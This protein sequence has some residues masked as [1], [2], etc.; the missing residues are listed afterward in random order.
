MTRLWRDALSTVSPGARPVAMPP[1]FYRDPSVLEAEIERLFLPGWICLCRADEIPETGDF[2]TR[3]VL[4]EPLVVTRSKQGIRVLSNVCRHRGSRLVHGSGSVK[5]LLCPYHAWTYDLEGRLVRA[6]LLDDQP[7]FEKTSCAL[8]SFPVTE[9]MGWVFV[10]LDGTAEPLA[11]LLTDLDPLVRNHHAEEMRTAHA[12]T[13]TWEVN[14]KGLAENFMEGYHLSQVH[15]KTLHPM[16]PTKLCRKGPHGPDFTTY[17][18][19]YDPGFRGR[20][21]AHADMT[22]EERALSMMVWIYP[23]FVAAI[24]PNSAVYMS[25]TPEG[26][27]CVQTRWGV[28]ARE[29]TFEGGEADARAAFATAFNA[30]DKA[31][32]IDMQKGLR[33]RFATGGPLAPADYEGTIWDFYQYLKH[34]LL[35]QAASG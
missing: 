26:P 8:P 5:R 4:D 23:G 29:T 31:R 28:I 33:S 2:L 30:E 1:T 32:L 6:P 24:S 9:W 17:K 25:L 7:G 3:E 19:H 10:N 11:P 14:W 16:T 20:T 22:E 13:E 12:E 35:S 27:E 18:A 21:E 15:L 34:R